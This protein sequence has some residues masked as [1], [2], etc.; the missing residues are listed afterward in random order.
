VVKA[1]LSPLARAACPGPAFRFLMD[2]GWLAVPHPG[3]SAP[4]TGTDGPADERPPGAIQVRT[5]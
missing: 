2:P 3:A 4:G 5:L 1:D